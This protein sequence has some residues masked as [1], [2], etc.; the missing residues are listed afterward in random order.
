M[1]L[2][3][4][5]DPLEPRAA[6]PGPLDVDDDLARLAR[7]SIEASFL[8]PDAKAALLHEIDQVVELAAQGQPSPEG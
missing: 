7:N 6:R 3:L 2:D 4:I 5:D 1:W 8:S